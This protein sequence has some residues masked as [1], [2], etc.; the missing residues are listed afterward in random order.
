MIEEKSLNEIFES[1]NGLEIK[2][3]VHKRG[4]KK[5]SKNKEK[6]IKKCTEEYLAKR[7]EKSFVALWER[8]K[9]G[10]RQRAYSILE[11]DDDT[12]DV[13]ADT[14]IKVLTKIEQYNAEKGELST[15]IF[16]ICKNEALAFKIAKARKNTVDNDIYDIYESELFK[17]DEFISD[18]DYSDK[19]GYDEDG[20]L[21]M[22]DEEEIRSKIFDTSLYEIS[23]FEDKRIATVMTERLTIYDT[24][25][26]EPKKPLSIEEIAKKYNYPITSVKNWVVKGRAQL[27]N[28]IF[29]HHNELYEMWKEILK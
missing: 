28:A 10:L 23:K 8:L 1:E 13:M 4:R 21:Y 6:S 14:L 3:E 27:K 25:T 15:W 2:V 20:D 22:M 19:F 16:N 7:D 12:D 9:W 5:G 17:S 11:N 24:K 18:F 29:E 26:R